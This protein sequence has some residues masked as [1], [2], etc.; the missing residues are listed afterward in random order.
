MILPAIIQL[1]LAEPTIS[2]LVGQNIYANQLPT[3]SPM[4]A[5][6]LTTVSGLPKQTLD[7]PGTQ[8]VNIQVDCFGASY[9]S[10]D[11]VRFATIMFLNR[12]SAQLNNGVILLVALFQQPIDFPNDWQTLQFRCCAEFDLHFNL[13]AAA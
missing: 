13:P 11:Q 12:K 8:K 1:L 3:A 4:P 6:V 10:A 2:S 5:M 7:G 9:A